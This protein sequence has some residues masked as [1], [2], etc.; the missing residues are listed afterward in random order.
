[1]AKTG[2]PTGVRL[3][4]RHQDMVRSKI[5]ASQLVNRLQDEALGKIELTDGQRDSAKYLLHK[6]LGN[7]PTVVEG[8]GDEG[9]HK[10][11]VSWRE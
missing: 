3:N 5:Q 11:E 10:L 9:E 2:N 4:R 7:A 8:P 1:M 6:I